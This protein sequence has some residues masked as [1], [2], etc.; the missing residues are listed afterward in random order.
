MF[1]L[2]QTSSLRLTPALRPVQQLMMATT[3]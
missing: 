3:A 1:K 2:F